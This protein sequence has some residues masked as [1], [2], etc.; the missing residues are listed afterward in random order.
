MTVA[1]APGSANLAPPPS[2]PS[3]PLII[4][5]LIAEGRLDPIAVREARSKDHDIPE[6]MLIRSG[7]VD[8]GT[9]AAAYAA[10]F[11]LPLYRQPEPPRPLSPELGRILPENLCREQMLAPISCENGIL[12]VAFATPNEMLFV[13]EIQFLTGCEV[14]A[15]IAS[16]SCVEDLIEEIFRAKQAE[17][18]VAGEEFDPTEEETPAG[19]EDQGG[20]LLL[21]QPP[22]PGPNGRIIRMVNQVID[23]A[24][25]SGASDIHLEPFEEN[26]KIRLRIDGKL[27]ELP[28]LH[29]GLFIKIISRFKI[30]AKMDIAERRIPQDGAITLKSGEKRIDLRVSTMPAVHGEKMVIRL[31]DKAAIPLE[32][33]SLGFDKRQEHDLIESIKMPHGL[34][35]VTGPTGSGKS[36]TLYTCL[37]LLNET[38]S[39]ICTVEDPVEYRFRG[40]NQVQVKPQIGL[41][42]ATALRAFLR[43]D[44]D[45][46]MVGEVRDQ[47][48][49]QICLRAALTGHFVLSTIHTNDA[50]SSITRLQDM[51]IEPFLLASTL[52]VLEAQRLVRK[53]C[54]LCKR[55]QICDPGTAQRY[56]LRPGETLFQPVGCEKC[57][58]VGYRGRIG[59]FEV[60]RITPAMSRHI[61]ARSS[62]PEMR[63][64]AKQEGMKLLFDSA[65][66][67]V[68]QGLTSLEIAVA[69]AI[70]ESE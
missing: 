6:R 66:D 35:F 5:L 31:L 22:P 23:Q 20:T 33:C 68:R 59:I 36:T 48:T 47:E 46:I 70:G 53:L 27:Q 7:L 56:G 44:P 26:C 29:R 69:T 62:L 60:I 51:G 37:N 25:R 9:I 57:R 1:V 34:M 65:I 63:A 2:E 61:L 30:L 10:H 40:M 42:F 52:R 4:D 54:P 8:A 39:N 58:G 50:L 19:E 67:K 45:I 16:L 3:S 43:Q 55:P 17:T 11:A 21:D 38:T 49:A 18:Y 32:L 12:E 14:R 64:A 13:D 24:I 41:N 15:S 28:Q